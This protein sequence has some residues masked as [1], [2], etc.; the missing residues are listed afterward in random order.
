[1]SDVLEA[2]RLVL[3]HDCSGRSWCREREDCEEVVACTKA[4]RVYAA[5]KLREAA[6]VCDARAKACGETAMR[7]DGNAHVVCV[8]AATT[9]EDLAD[10]I[11]AMAD[12]EQTDQR[13]DQK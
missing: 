1:M 10:E 2:A 13:K 6:A 3:C 11:R 5:A 8:Q 7:M 4:C 12:A 9:A